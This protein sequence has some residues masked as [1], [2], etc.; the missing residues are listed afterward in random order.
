MI[1]T[2]LESWFRIKRGHATEY[3]VATVSAT[4]PVIMLSTMIPRMKPII[5]CLVIFSQAAFAAIDR[6]NILWITSEDHGPHLGSYGDTF[7]TTPNIDRLA[8][9]GL[10]YSRCWSGAPVCAPARTALISGLYPSST[11]AEHM[12]SLSALPESFRMYPQLL[13]E[14]GYYC[15]NNSK[16]DYNLRKPGQVWDESSAKAHWR[17]RKSGQPFFAVFNSTKSHESQIR[18]RPHKAVHDPAK[19]RLPGYHPDAPEI[20][21]DW[22]QYHDKVSEADA[23]AGRYLRELEEAGLMADT[24]IFY[25]A[26]HGSGMPRNKR[27]LYNS[28]LHVP[29]IVVIPDKWR[30]LAP[31]DYKPGAKTGRLVSFVDFAPTLLSLAGIKPPDWLQGGAF[32]GKHEAEQN[33]FLHGYRA[34]MDERQDLSR[35][36]TDGRFVYIRNFMPHLPCGQYLDYMFQ[37]PTTRV[38]KRLFDEGKLNA[39][40]SAFWRQKPPEELYDLQTDPDEIRN[41]AVL[42]EHQPLLATLRNEM[43]AHAIRIRD[44]SLL[45]EGEMHSRAAGSTPYEMGHDLV[46]F[47]ITKILETAELAS[48][49]KADSVPQLKIALGDTDSAVRYWAA[50]GF[51][52]RGQPAVELH[53]AELRKLTKDTSPF[54]RIV[55]AQSLAQ[56]GA[57]SDLNAALETLASLSH[58]GRN[59]VFV[60][61]S[62]LNSIDALD[63]KAAGL[64]P[65]LRL[66]PTK[67][68]LPDAR[69]STYVPRLL[70]KTLADLEIRRER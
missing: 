13:R 1:R 25:F 49:L 16:E 56:F 18:T 67:G 21:Q 12:R 33:K 24:L 50:M 46:K 22:A 63:K 20:R 28:G 51:L 42:P 40:Q 15:S 41:L 44:V 37:T 17:N 36:V 68:P 64:E 59:D 47:P 19:V 6:P 27:W 3:R 34:R 66:L 61:V 55:A 70:E 9:R 26:D 35:S 43:R 30:H 10:L 62:A 32:M 48:S 2:A 39:A 60:A 53:L 23:D 57:K 4:L 38:W 58:W 5:L 45:P 14:A 11:G 31:K 65:I 8:A 54:V 52:M 69:L 7:A 29:L